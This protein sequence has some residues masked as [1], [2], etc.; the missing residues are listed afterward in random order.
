MK[1]D[2]ESVRNNLLK[3]ELRK[4]IQNKRNNLPIWDR[5]KRSKIIAE[6]FFNTAYYINSN[7]ILIYYPFR[8][9]IDVTIIIRQALKNKKNII[10]PRVHDRKLKLFYIDNLK[11][12]LEIGAY[13]IMEPTTGLCRVAK[14]SGID[15]VIVPGLVFDKNLN[16]LGYGGGFYDRLLPLIP[17][18]VK[19]I[20]LCFDIQ[21]VESIPVSEHDIK[22]DLLITDTNIYHP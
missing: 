21:V 11:K 17:A 4:K 12:Q 22:V 2:N 13:G 18:G 9:E 19:K 16:R 20:A 10:L 8:S 5:K 14:I 7:N 6:K 15:L 3:K 1:N